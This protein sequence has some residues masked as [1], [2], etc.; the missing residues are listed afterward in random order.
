MSSVYTQSEWHAVACC[1]FSS[2]TILRGSGGAITQTMNM[3]NA[4]RG[5]K[6]L[7]MRMVLQYQR[8]GKTERQETDITNFPGGL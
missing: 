3:T 4:H 1:L 8:A 6:P 2:S 7:K 5:T